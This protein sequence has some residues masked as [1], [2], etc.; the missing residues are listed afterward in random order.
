MVKE[1]TLSTG[2]LPPEGL[3]RKNVVRITDHPDMMAVNRGPQATI[4]TIA[5]LYLGVWA[6]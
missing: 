2:K 4:Q 3:P 5:N 6:L 1:C